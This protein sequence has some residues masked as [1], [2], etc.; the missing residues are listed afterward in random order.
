MILQGK[1]SWLDED[2]EKHDSVQVLDAET[3]SLINPASKYLATFLAEEEDKYTV[4][5]LP[6]E[7]KKAN[8]IKAATI[9]G[10]DNDFSMDF[11]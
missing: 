5:V 7:G 11:D 10:E 6:N 1:F 8:N 4:D 3:T 2:S 9:V